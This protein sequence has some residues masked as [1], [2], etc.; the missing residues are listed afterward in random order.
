MK[1]DLKYAQAIKGRVTG[2]GI[3]IIDTI[4]LVEVSRAIEVLEASRLL[5]AADLES[6][7]GWF[8]DY[9]AWLTTHSY[10]LE[11]REARNNHGVCWVMQVA[12]FARLTRNQEL[13]DYCRERFKTVLIPNQMAADGSFPL[14]MRRT[15]PYGYSL[16]NLEAMAA[17]CELLST[18]DQDLWKFELPDGRGMRKGLE[19]IVPHVR[20]KKRW[21]LAPDVMYDQYWPM[22]QSFLLFGGLRLERPEYVELWKKLPA[23][24]TVREVIRNF[25]IRQPVIWIH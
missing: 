2:R 11:E 20:D 15:K 21:P 5:T 9:L 14:E 13:I 24:S 7:R 1:P 16:F 3:G 8:R 17:I 18:S 19:F 10:G 25:F 22:R 23:D 12:A 6:T 4:H